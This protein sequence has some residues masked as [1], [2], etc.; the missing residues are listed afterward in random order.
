MASTQKTHVTTQNKNES[1][2]LLA[3]G[4]SGPW[5]ID[6]DEAISGADRWW[7][8]IE[9]PPVSFYFELPS[10]DIVG[11]MARFLKSKNSDSF[12]IGRDKSTPISLV[13]DDEFDDRFF[14][15]IGPTDNVMVRFV[16]AGEDVVRISEA[17]QQVQE[18]LDEKTGCQCDS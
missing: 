6:I 11:K 15:L 13:Q 17:L 14:L 3:C 4:S 5:Q 16:I 18:D 9:G 10:L 1:F 12:V 8:Q 7:A 2:G